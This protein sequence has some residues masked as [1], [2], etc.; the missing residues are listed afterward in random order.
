MIL[1]FDFLSHLYNTVIRYINNQ[2][3]QSFPVYALLSYIVPP[4]IQLIIYA[5][6]ILMSVGMIIR[7]A[8]Q[9]KRQIEINQKK[10]LKEYLMIAVAI[11]LQNII[12]LFLVVIW[13]LN[14]AYHLIYYLIPDQN[15]QTMSINDIFIEIGHLKEFLLQ[16][17]IIFNSVMTLF[18]MEGYRLAMWTFVKFLMQKLRAYGEKVGLIP[19]T[20]V[21]TK[22]TKVASTT[23][24]REI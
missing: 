7:I 5:S 24:R 4:T 22:V 14:I 23:S 15:S 6:N 16:L 20:T 1:L 11:L 9:I 17:S 12:A 10:R 19:K 18:V 8:I 13:M 2:I 21:F 3:D